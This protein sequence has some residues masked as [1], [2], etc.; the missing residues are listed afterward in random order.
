M[1]KRLVSVVTILF[2]FLISVFL[3]ES[4]VGEKVYATS[5]DL[6]SDNLFYNSQ[7]YNNDLASACASICLD[8]ENVAP[9]FPEGQSD[10]YAW[11]QD[12]AAFHVGIG[13]KEIDINGSPKNLVVIV[14]RGTSINAFEILGDWAKDLRHYPWE[15]QEALFCPYKYAESIQADIHQFIADHSEVKDHPIVYLVTG[16]SLGGAAANLAAAWLTNQNRTGAYGSDKVFCYTFGAIKAIAGEHNAEDG[17]HN[18]FNI[19][20]YFDSFGP[21]GGNA[22]LGVSD[23]Y[24]KFGY[25]FFCSFKYDES[26]PWSLE[27]HDMGNYRDEVATGR[28][29]VTIDR[30][31]GKLNNGDQRWTLSEG[32]LKILGTGELS[33]SGLVLQSASWG[34]Y[35]DDVT[36]I[37]IQDG[38]TKIGENGFSYC[39][40]LEEIHIPKSVTT[41]G[42]YAFI[43]CDSLQDIYYSGTHAEWDAIDVD[44]SYANEA[45][46]NAT[47]HC[48]G[49]EQQ[50]TNQS[51]ILDY[52]VGTTR[53]KKDTTL[54]RDLE[55]NGNLYMDAGNLDLDGHTVTV[56]G[57]VYTNGGVLSVDGTLIVKGNLIQLG[58]D[59]NIYE[60]RLE[61][62]GKHEIG[63]VGDNG[64][65]YEG[66]NYF[67]NGGEEIVAGDFTSYKITQTWHNDGNYNTFA[68]GGKLTIGGNLRA[69]SG[70]NGNGELTM[71]GSD[72][73][74]VKGACTSKLIIENAAG[75]EVTFSGYVTP[76]EL[77]GEGLRVTAEDLRFG[78]KLQ[79]DLTVDGDVVV[80]SGINLNNKTL[81]INGNCQH[82]ADSINLNHGKMVVSGD[83]SMAGI[84]GSIVSEAVLYMLNDDDQMTIGGNMLV[85]TTKASA[86][87][88]GVLKIAGDFTQINGSSFEATNKHKT[89]LN[90]T[91]L[92]RITFES[93]PS[94]TFNLLDLRQERENYIFDPE[95]CWNS[96]LEYCDHSE[97]EV[98]N[99]SEASCIEDGYTGDTY[100][101]KC[102]ELIESGFVI[103]ANGHC[104]VYSDAVAA[105]CTTD[106]VTEGSHCSVCGEVIEG[107][108]V[109]PA[110]GHEWNDG[111]VTT[112]PTDSTEGVMTY[113]CLREGCGATR[114]E[115][116]GMIDHEYSDKWSSDDDAHWHDCTHENCDSVDAY[117]E[118]VWV[119]SVIT[120]PTCKQVG[121]MEYT[122]EV[123]G[124]T[125][126]EAIEKTNHT[127]NDFYTID[128]Q[129]TCAEEGSESIHCANCD[130]TK[131]KR[132]IAKT[133]HKYSSWTTT[134]VATEIA[135]GQQTRK[136]SVCGKTETKTVAQLKPT[137]PAVTIVKPVAAKKA[138]TIKWKKVSS[139]NQKKI[140][141][142]QI[143]YSTD[144]N[145]KKGVKT[146]YAKKSATSKKITKLTSKKTYYVRIRAY[147]SSGGVVHVSKWSKTQNAKA[148]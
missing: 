88:N 132:T 108:E 45:L 15:D 17:Y 64:N 116:I 44:Y 78:A 76:S 85:N 72:P 63:S 10:Q 148:K 9:H 83:Y 122:C 1:R 106:G 59:L 43:S 52:I 104:T 141:K 134:K 66:G 35:I 49:D 79:N 23:P 133:S 20:N 99:A 62:D 146:V 18:I 55:I 113:T 136:C 41:I 19:Y 131:E 68:N 24:Y 47:L 29:E 98:R 16:H 120:Q 36:D 40:G 105:T 96:L 81:V 127:W 50:G 67:N 126:T 87:S 123:C 117:A 74:L 100:C 48:L 143:Q 129:A 95:P 102:G 3:T 22:P 147:K 32:V 57:D 26:S 13:Y 39:E 97:I 54:I 14:C 8:V 75:R 110:L 28:V 82:I 37:V 70:L 128:V 118:H 94:A 56:Y 46:Q 58:G 139:K 89:V 71:A 119:G 109:I 84:D 137:L 11:D 138:A 21:H 142:I 60:G 91:G 77:S 145:F 130:A 30:K 7:Y 121:E 115:T 73:V 140:A 2:F 112:A 12:S 38:I 90:G 53:I 107:E 33:D 65:Y 51:D 125:R 34:R 135:A 111:E 27:N 5:N 31:A 101:K 80:D 25:T 61:V 103:K 114:T 69:Y 42:N 6:L 86:L 93:Y 144:K 124:K 92:Q 4:T